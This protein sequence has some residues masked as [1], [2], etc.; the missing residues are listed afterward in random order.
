MLFNPLRESKKQD[1]PDFRLVQ[2]QFENWVP[3][4]NSVGVYRCPETGKKFLRRVDQGPHFN[5]F[6]K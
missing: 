2:L 6:K 4:S 1:S 5:S 3:F